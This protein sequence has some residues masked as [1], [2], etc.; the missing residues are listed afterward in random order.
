MDKSWFFKD[1]E[2][3]S[4]SAYRFPDR[5][6]SNFSALV[7]AYC[8]EYMPWHFYLLHCLRI[9][10]TFQKCK[11]EFS[12]LLNLLEVLKLHKHDQYFFLHLFL[13]YLYLRKSIDLSTL[14]NKV[15]CMVQQR[16]LFYKNRKK[17][18]HFF[19]DSR[20]LKLILK[21]MIWPWRDP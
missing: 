11:L 10:N 5:F 20:S 14:Q 1:I 18:N 16:C 12:F 3:Q 19:V 21:R 8:R 13:T 15:N 7:F 6:S 2:C 17:S 9:L 4:K